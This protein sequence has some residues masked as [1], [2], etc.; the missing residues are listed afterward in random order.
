[1]SKLIFVCVSRNFF[2]NFLEL[3]A[4]QSRHNCTSELFLA[5]QFSQQSA[6]ACPIINFS[7][8]TLPWAYDLGTPEP[9][10][11]GSQRS[12]VSIKTNSKRLK[13][14]VQKVNFQI[15]IIWTSNNVFIYIKKWLQYVSNLAWGR[16]TDVFGY[17]KSSNW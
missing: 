2:L 8:L 13:T 3:P 4:R 10:G 11:D 12:A 7:A 5:L 14:K 17:T 1:M 9:V 6:V 16:F 15:L